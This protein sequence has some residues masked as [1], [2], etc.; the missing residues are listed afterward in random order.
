MKVATTAVGVN[1]FQN[2]LPHLV[3]FKV[4]HRRGLIQQLANAAV[5]LQRSWRHPS[6]RPLHALPIEGCK[7]AGTVAQE[8]IRHFGRGSLFPVSQRTGFFEQGRKMGTDIVGFSCSLV[9]EP[10]DR[11]L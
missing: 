3:A 2:I 11:V 8:A 1:L 9:I 5:S 10:V 4:P 7:N 6:E